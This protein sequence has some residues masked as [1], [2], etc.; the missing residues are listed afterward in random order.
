MENLMINSQKATWI[1]RKELGGI[2]VP[3]KGESYLL[4][5]G[6]KLACLRKG[7][8]LIGGYAQDRSDVDPYR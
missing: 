4:K 8:Y 3:S 6:A 1:C 7:M 5:T 2:K